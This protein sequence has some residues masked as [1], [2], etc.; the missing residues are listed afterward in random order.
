MNAYPLSWPVTWQRT[1]YRKSS[2]FGAHS[3]AE[4]VDE[5]LR[6]LRLLSA[7]SVVISTNLALRNDGLPRSNQA[8]PGDSGAA[9]YFRLKGADRVLACDRWIKVEDNLWSIAKHI[10]SIRGQARWGVGTV[11]QAFTGYA[12]LPAPAAA[13]TWW[14]VLGIPSQRASADE[15]NAAWKRLMRTAHPDAGG[16]D[17]LAARINTARDEGLKAVGA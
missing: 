17:D 9:V 15:L 12:A 4:C 14:E 7:T 1:K 2:D 8:N 5:I 11:E 13:D 10:D 6:Q 16:S 3:I